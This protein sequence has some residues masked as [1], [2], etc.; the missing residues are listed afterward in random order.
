MRTIAVVFLV[1]F[2]A[3]PTFAGELVTRDKASLYEKPDKN[4]AVLAVFGPNIKLTFDE[5]RDFWHHV[6]AEVD[7]R[8]VAGWVSAFD[9]DT[10][11]GRSKGQ[12]LEENKRLFDEVSELRKKLKDQEAL[13]KDAAEKLAKAQA[14][15]TD[16]GAG[17]AALKKDLAQAN[18]RLQ[19]ALDE[20]GRL[21]A[22]LEKARKG[23]K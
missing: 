7:G 1:L 17:V 11:M 12:L 4:S 16:A 18:A 8:K 5:T 2:A 15:L 20:L 22:E 3:L 13:T 23:E 14:D 19:A 21:K 10:M 9:A 6:T